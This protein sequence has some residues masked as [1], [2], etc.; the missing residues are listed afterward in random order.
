MG[1]EYDLYPSVI[2][3]QAALESNWGTSRLGR[4]PFIISS[5]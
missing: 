5:G 3:A 4:A 2:I 1:T